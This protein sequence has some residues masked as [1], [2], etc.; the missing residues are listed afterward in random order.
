MDAAEVRTVL[1][2]PGSNFIIPHLSP[3]YRSSSFPIKDSDFTFIRSWLIW[4]W[5][6]R[7]TIY[8]KEDNLEPKSAASKLL[9][10]ADLL[11]QLHKNLHP[12]NQHIISFTSKLHLA[13][14]MQFS[15]DTNPLD[16]VE[17]NVP[18]NEKYTTNITK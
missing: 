11:D 2:S 10:A 9:T 5:I 17:V 14:Q 3:A 15:D 16:Y 4:L 1:L 8:P 18:R 6:D 13:N 12:P 7:V